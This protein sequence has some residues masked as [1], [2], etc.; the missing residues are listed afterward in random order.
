MSS[1]SIGFILLTH[2]KPRQIYRLINKLNIMFNYPVIVCHHD[3]S[4]CD[5]SVEMPKNVFLVRPYIQTEWG[6][7]SLVEATVRALEIMYKASDVPD[8][9][10][11]LSGADYPIKAARQILDELNSNP[12]D[13]YIQYEQITYQTYKD[14]LIPSMLWL[15][16]SYERYCT[17][18]FIF[19][20][21]KK[22]YAKFNPE[23]HL[24]HPLLT[25]A[26]LPFSK[27]L[28]CF[29]GSQ[30]FCANRK[31]AEYIIDFHTKKNAIISHYSKIKKFSDE[32]YFQTILANASHLK[33]K[34]DRQR[35]ID[36]S[37]GGPHPKILLMED[38]PHLLASSAHF[39]RKFDIDIDSK[40]LDELDMI[41]SV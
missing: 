31:A 25:K 24:E 34:N 10:V 20:Y 19:N 6:G 1:K 2:T 23:I 35:Y 21:S 5:L 14:D 33:L 9:F 22:T 15:K 29:S 32:S 7:F 30:W 12:Y 13:A 11:L 36:W 17:K 38:L 4:K 18:S 8:W 28:T 39:A 37:D 26:F 3:F 27:K 40:I 41:I 16:N